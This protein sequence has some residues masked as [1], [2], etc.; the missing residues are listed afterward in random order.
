MAN[1]LADKKGKKM[2]LIRNMS[3]EDG[4]DGIIPKKARHRIPGQLQHKNIAMRN[5]G[6][7]D[8]GW[9]RGHHS[10][11]YDAYLTLKKKYPLVAEEFR[12]ACGFNERGAF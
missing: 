5:A 1:R 10:G 11:L 9:M 3:I 8:L 4:V 6:R 2:K 7:I 12:K